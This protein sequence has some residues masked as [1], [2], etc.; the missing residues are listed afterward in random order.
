MLLRELFEDTGNGDMMVGLRQQVIDY[1]IPAVS[2][3]VEFVTVQ[4][5]ETTLRNSRTGLTIDRGLIMQI[6]DPTKMTMVK[7]V[8]GDKVYL[9]VT[10]AMNSGGNTSEDEAAKQAD[11]LNNKA[12]A[13]AVKSIKA[14]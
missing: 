14:K 2:H 13:Q 6:L 1:L 4:D 12:T 7:K 8:E 9:S 10:S 11:D 3:D 5:I